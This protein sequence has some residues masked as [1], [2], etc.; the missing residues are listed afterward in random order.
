MSLIDIIVPIYNAEKYLKT[1]L[2]S[3]YEQS[4]PK[5]NVIAVN[6]GSTDASL[7]ICKEYDNKYENFHLRTTQNAG[8]SAARNLALSFSK[9]PYIVFVDSDDYLEKNYLEY[10][11]GLL[12]NHSDLGIVGYRYVLDNQKEIMQSRIFSIKD[13]KTLVSNMLSNNRGVRTVLWNKIFVA[14]IIKDNKL[15]FSEDISIGEDFIFLI[16][17]I[18]YV[19]EFAI[20]DSKL[21]NYRISEN[22][23]MNSLKTDR[24]FSDKNMD[25]W[26]AIIEIEKKLKLYDFW[27]VSLDKDIFI[28][29]LHIANKILKYQKNTDVGA[30]RNFIYEKRKEIILEDRIEFKTKF[31]I[32]L[33]WLKAL[34]V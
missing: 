2:D 17:Y 8:V 19:S 24:I 13:K 10:L 15:K 26:K 27:D 33:R 7:E 18:N 3:I 12:D 1:C 21:Y 14:N 25:E 34:V 16:K 32:L 22:S 9:S 29:K 11:Y 23:T 28:K 4:F 6:D 31:A 5:F 20:I 30:I